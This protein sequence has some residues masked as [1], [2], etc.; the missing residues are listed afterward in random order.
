MIY[1]S[2]STLACLALFSTATALAEEETG[3]LTFDGLVAIEDARVGMAYVDPDADFTVFSRVAI[4]DPYVAF[5][6]NWQREQNRQR[7][8]RV[9]DGDMERIKADVAD[10]FRDVFIEVLEAENGFTV[11]NGAA[12]D[13]LLLRPAIIELDITA[14]DRNT[15]GRQNTFTATTGSATLYIELFDSTTG[16]ILGRAADRGVARN[17]GNQVTWSNRVTNRADARRMFRGWATSLRQFLEENY[18]KPS[19]D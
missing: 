5:R 1:R 13:V 14:V 8:R 4:M 9:S 16:A 17:A 7:G 10:L 3:D 15:A 2:F 12:D 19:S 11:V 18:M 6:T